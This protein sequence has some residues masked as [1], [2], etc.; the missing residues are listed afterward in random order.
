M[1]ALFNDS[2]CVMLSA[3]YQVNDTRIL[4]M[5]SRHR[6]VP[7]VEIDIQDGRSE[8]ALHTEVIFPEHE[9]QSQKL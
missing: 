7:L 2:R 9:K 3:G 1:E 5:H 6:C 8:V 4:A